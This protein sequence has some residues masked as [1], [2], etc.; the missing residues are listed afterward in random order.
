M[1]C[2]NRLQGLLL[3][4]RRELTITLAAW[5]EFTGVGGDMVFLSDVQNLN[6]ARAI[7]KV[8]A[9]FKD[10]RL[11]QARL[12]TL[13]ATC[14]DCVKLVSVSSRGPDCELTDV[15]HPSFQT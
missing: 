7:R 10:L 14:D 12:E 2:L 6:V 3:E 8:E 4:L 13:D 1:E 9:L 15:V 5:N 11:L